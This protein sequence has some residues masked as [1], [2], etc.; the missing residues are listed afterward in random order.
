[1]LCEEALCGGGAQRCW[2]EEDRAAQ[3]S[4]RQAMQGT[5]LWATRSHSALVTGPER[6][7]R[8]TLAWPAW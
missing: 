7:L 6:S 1:M 3:R 4:Q 5:V 2:Q 8:S